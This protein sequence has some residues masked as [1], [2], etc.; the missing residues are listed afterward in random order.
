LVMDRIAL[1]HAMTAHFDAVVAHMGIDATLI[2]VCA[3]GAFDAFSD[4]D[5]TRHDSRIA[6]AAESLPNCT[7]IMLAQFSMASDAKVVESRVSCPVLTSPDSA[8]RRLKG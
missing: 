2:S 6:E 5:A 4:R 1:I 3:K 8:V 7:V